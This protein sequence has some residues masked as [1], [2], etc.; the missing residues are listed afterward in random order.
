MTPPNLG[1]ARLIEPKD[2]IGSN[3]AAR[4]L[5]ITKATLSRRISSGTLAPLARLDG[6]RGAFV[7]DLNDIRT[8][9]QRCSG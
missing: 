9:V 6:P 7:F 3:E 5:G 1:G 4:L 2:L 8:E